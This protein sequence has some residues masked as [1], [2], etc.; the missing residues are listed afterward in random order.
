M[1]KQKTTKIIVRIIWI[2][3][4][5]GVFTIGLILTLISSGKLGY[6]P[7]FDELENPKT[8]LATEIYSS[9]GVILGKYYNENRTIVQ[10]EDLSPN[11]VNALLAT[12]DIRFYSHSGI[13]FR[14]LSRV[15][16]KSLLLGQSAGGGSTISQQ[17]A[18]NLY[19]M[20]E[21]EIVHSRSK[22]GEKFS[23]VIQKFQEWVT[24]AKLERNYTKD[25]IMV[26]YLNT[27]TFGHNAYG[28]KSAAN[29]F[30]GKSPD[31]LSIDQAAILVGLLKAPTKYSPILNPDNAFRRRNTVYAQIERYQR[32][33]HRLTGWKIKPKSYFDSLEKLPIKVDYHKQSHNEGLATYF[34]EFLRTYLTAHKPQRKNYPSWNYQK[35][36]DDSTNWVRDP[37]YGWCNKNL[38]P[39]GEP[40]NIYRDGLNIY[41]TINSRMQRYA[42]NAV[43]MHLGK[44][45]EPLQVAFE[46]QMRYF[47]NPPFANN[48]S[49]KD[50]EKILKRSMLRSERW[51]VMRNEGVS[52][53]KIKQSFFKPVKM[54]VFS[55]KGD[56]DTVMTPFDSIM[57]YKKFLRAGFVSI[58]PE[59]GNV[60][61]YVGGIDFNYFKFDH[62]MVSRRQVG[63]TF[64]PFVYTLAMMPG[65]YSPCYKVQNIP[66][67]I[68]VWNNG[69]KKD[70][71][72]KFSKS[73]FDDQM[74]SLKMGLALSLNQISAWVIK[75]YGP[76]AVIKVAR[77]MG[78]ESPLPVVYSLCVGAAE[79]KLEEMVSAYCTF[80]NKGVHVSPIFVTKIEDRYGNVLASFTPTK[81][82]AIDENT[83]YRVIELMRGVVQF[84]TSVRLRIKY[85]LTNDIAGKTGT[86]NDNSDGWFIGVTPHLVSGAWVGGEERSVRFASTALGQGA[87]MALPIWALYMQQVYADPTLPYKKTDVFQKPAISDGVISNCDD[88][89]DESDNNNSTNN[90]D[91]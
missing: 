50:V 3:T 47:R 65:G 67:T 74:I 6:I 86:T 27:V 5:L 62:V 29:T 69:K 81:N 78:I 88:F 84:G 72:P 34:R 10:F 32:R 45:K 13:D 36:I 40:Y 43:A 59:T 20:R 42:E 24:A 85:K 44:G 63:S 87:N 90:I 75:Q 17:L 22:I 58:E 53:K 4:L 9:D 60:R 49:K 30:F 48:V 41:T 79:V 46:K 18:K 38:K 80:A 54:T 89:H 77:S 31:S 26:M 8:N 61:A 64:K 66:Y 70:Y 57:Y 56:I 37:L 35:F 83:A 16:V 11:V 19:R 55:W 71:T 33:L 25:E 15:L 76:E 14:A 51:H 82:Q 1:D 39:N 23:M 21:K 2:G 91:F 12:E 7:P 68:Q 73:R 28:I 52:E